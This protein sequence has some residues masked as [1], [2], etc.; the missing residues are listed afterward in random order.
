MCVVTEA[1][2][3][4]VSVHGLLGPHDPLDGTDMLSRNV[5]NHHSTL[6]NIPEERTADYTA[7]EA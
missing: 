3:R 2:C 1:A 7:V 6:R 4:F 5:G